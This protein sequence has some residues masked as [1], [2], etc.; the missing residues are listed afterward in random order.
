MGYTYG[1]LSELRLPCPDLPQENFR[2]NVRG[3]KNSIDTSMRVEVVARDSGFTVV[4][5]ALPMPALH[6]KVTN[7]MGACKRIGRKIPDCKVPHFYR[8]LR[9][10]VRLFIRK[11]GL[12]P[13]EPDDP[14][15]DVK[16]WLDATNYNEARKAQLLKDMDQQDGQ[17]HLQDPKGA[18]HVKQHTKHE[19]YPDYKHA[20]MIN[21]R[22]DSFKWYSGPF[23]KCVEE[24][25]FDPSGP[26]GKYFVKHIPV[27]ER[28]KFILERLR[29]EGSIYRST[30]YSSFE[31]Q[32]T[33]LLMSCVEMQLYEFMARNLPTRLKTDIRE[34]LTGK[35][36]ISSKEQVMSIDG[37]R[38]SGDMCTSLGNGFTNLMLMFFVCSEFGIDYEAGEVDGIVEGDDGNFS[39][40]GELED[41]IPTT[42]DFT[43]RGL[44]LKVTEIKDLS[45]SDFCG[46]KFSE[47]SYDNILDPADVMLKFGWITGLQLRGKLTTILALLRAK[48]FSLIYEAPNS[49]I[50]RAM[51]E[52]VLR[53]TSGIKCMFQ[54]STN[55]KLTWKQL[56]I[57][58][59]IDVSNIENLDLPKYVDNKSTRLTFAKMFGVDIETQYRIEEY[60]K[61]LTSLEHI[62]AWI[63]DAVSSK[64]DINLDACRDYYDR[65]YRVI[66][67]GQNDSFAYPL[68]VCRADYHNSV[69]AYYG[70]IA[71][72]PKLTTTKAVFY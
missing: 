58:H 32:Q 17:I 64:T 45:M 31:S 69:S 2:I 65:F 62:P 29:R 68:D 21:A 39:F 56:Q 1:S 9:Q 38:M 50:L 26:T 43:D 44:I 33:D 6:D 28:P 27:R 71:R 3:W 5:Y 25:L 10:F 60:F 42:Q 46:L 40:H 55:Y 63:F 37:T 61:K 70:E 47:D 12:Q 13:L 22:V 20:R 72:M 53:L 52:C 14:R 15:L 24:A 35:Q 18:R 48:A 23:F 4:D 67:V 41:R 51:A 57:F 11:S 16:N 7:F 30:D 54:E 66:P 19:N 49:P 36:F 34:V 8:R 59:G